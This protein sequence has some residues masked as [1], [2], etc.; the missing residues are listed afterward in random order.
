MST[1]FPKYIFSCKDV[2]THEDNT[3]SYENVFENLEVPII[4]YEIEFYIVLGIEYSIPKKGNR[5]LT[6]KLMDPGDNSISDKDFI[7]E[8]APTIKNQQRFSLN[9]INV[10]E[11]YIER[12]GMYSIL[13]YHNG[14]L[15][16]RH[17]FMV[18]GVIEHDTIV[19]G[20][21]TVSV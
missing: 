1:I 19:N 21:K 5:K 10:S 13:V 9:I 16:T 18:E 4:P 6:V 3:V 17:D 12:E 11:F 20:N 14:E 8:L 15:F 2:R 7:I